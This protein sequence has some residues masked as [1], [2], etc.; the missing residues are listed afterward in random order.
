[1]GANFYLLTYV[2]SNS[3]TKK[4]D[5]GN[6]CLETSLIPWGRIKS[7]PPV[8]SILTPSIAVWQLRHADGGMLEC[9]HDKGEIRNSGAKEELI[10]TPSTS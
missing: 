5:H 4:F 9:G 8:I 1:M 3:R 10:S 6:L 7:S 2:F